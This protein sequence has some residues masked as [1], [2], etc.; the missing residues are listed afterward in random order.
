VQYPA[1]KIE[2]FWSKVD[3][4]EPDACWEWRGARS[5]K[6]YGY[7][8]G[9]RRF[10]APRRTHRIAWELANNRHVPQGLIVCHHC[11]N[12]PCVNPDHLFV[13]TP[14][15][16]MRDMCA[17]GRHKSA[18]MLRAKAALPPKP[19]IPRVHAEYCIKCGHHRT[20]DYMKPNRRCRVCMKAKDARRRAARKAAEQS[21]QLCGQGRP[22]Q[23]P[24]GV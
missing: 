4:R 13:G 12:P 3:R 24:M 15:D 18:A 16:N 23:P 14:A 17:K 19:R 11:D 8:D 21:A 2:K 6:G 5:E 9:L 1:N 22:N 20:D 7:Y 10:G